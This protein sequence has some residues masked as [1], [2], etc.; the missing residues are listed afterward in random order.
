[1]NADYSSTFKWKSAL[2]KYLK[3]EKV[4]RWWKGTDSLMLEYFPPGIPKWFV[5]YH[6]LKS[7][8]TQFIVHE[9]WYGCDEVKK[10]LNHFYN[11]IDLI[12]KEYPN[13]YPVK[14]KTKPL[15]VLIHD[16][17]DSYKYK[18]YAHWKFGVDII[19][20][21]KEETNEWCYFLTVDN[22]ANMNVVFPL[23]DCCL[24]PKRLKGNPR[25]E[26]VEG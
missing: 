6:R 3:G 25:L 2:I 12:Y 21:V 11:S 18:K 1:M 13:I 22:F 7:R 20:Q 15:V 23:V 5:L 10:N 4:V 26:E 19:D 14:I 16:P 8:L 17:S 24:L 9:H